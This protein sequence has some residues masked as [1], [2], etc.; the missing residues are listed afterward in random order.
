MQ[1]G[2]RVPNAGAMMLIVASVWLGLL[3]SMAV[4]LAG[5]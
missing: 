5:R 2:E 3:V 1:T 4:L